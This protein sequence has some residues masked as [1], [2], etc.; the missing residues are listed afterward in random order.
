M[1]KTPTKILNDFNDKDIFPV[2]TFYGKDAEAQAARYEIFKSVC[3]EWFGERIVDDDDNFPKFFSRNVR[4]YYPQYDQLLRVQPAVIGTTYDWMIEDYSAALTHIIGEL[5]NSGKDT[6]HVTGETTN[7]SN[8]SQNGWTEGK[9]ED[10]HT[11]NDTTTRTPDLT[12]DDTLTKS[13][14]EKTSKSGTDT[15]TTTHGK[16]VTM[17]GDEI[18]DYGANGIVDTRSIKGSYV[19]HTHHETHDNTDNDQ[20]TTTSGHDDHKEASKVMP[21]TTNNGASV[22]AAGSDQVDNLTI[23]FADA[24]STIGATNDH[25]HQNVK[26]T[27][28]PKIEHMGNDSTERRYGMHLDSKGGILQ[29][30]P[31]DDYTETNT[32][33]GQETTRYSG[34]VDKEGGTTTV[35]HG[36][37]SSNELTFTGRQDHTVHTETGTDETKTDYNSG[38]AGSS[39]Q[40]TTQSTESNGGGTTESTTTAEKGTTQNTT[41][42]NYTESNGRHRAPAEIMENA[43]TFIESTNAWAWIQDKL[44][45]CFFG[46][47]DL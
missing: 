37:D 26:V 29:D 5:K 27:G 4:K 28:G 25:T 15:D 43:V 16:T 2:L 6:T 24:P 38:T 20:E 42:E 18:H 45:P 33:K 17:S 41:N 21:M 22:S 30:S 7:N 13:G 19:D 39:S 47:W 8:V 34:R 31:N 35:E 11:G 10:N 3:H 46:V 40:H 44:E 14:S 32:K 9:T 23:D 1:W 36:Y 12:T